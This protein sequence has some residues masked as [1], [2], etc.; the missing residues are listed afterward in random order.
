MS[1]EALFVRNGEGFRAT[2]LARGPWDPGALHGGAPASLLVHAFES[3]PVAPGLRL[4]R[5]T[6]EFVRP[7]PLGKLF[8]A[9]E[10]TRPGRRVSLLEATLRDEGGTEVT[11]ARAL[12]VRPGEVGESRDEPPPFPG[13][14]AG[15][16]NDFQNFDVTMFATH[17][18]EI[19]FVEGGFGELGPAT[20]WF[21][22]RHPIVAGESISPFERMAAAGDFGNG[23]ASELTWQDHLFINPDLTIYFER[24]P[25]GE[26]L[27]LQSQMRVVPGNV[28][29]AESVLWDEEGRIGRATQA[30]LVEQRPAT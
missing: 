15:R 27:A 21:R 28:A 16:V 18:M 9:A 26:W 30:L 24:P 25:R 22:L 19:R 10:V 13:P 7:V 20:A 14:D 3:C 1:L 6:Y 8:V 11:R 17:G 4:A 29:V 5:V 23:I 2:E 12:L